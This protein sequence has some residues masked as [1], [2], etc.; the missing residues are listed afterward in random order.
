MA[1]NC[2][3]T[4]SIARTLFMFYRINFEKLHLHLHLLI[5]WIRSVVQPVRT[6]QSRGVSQSV[7][8]TRRDKPGM[9][10]KFLA[11]LRGI[12]LSTPVVPR[13]QI[14]VPLKW[15]CC[16][17][18]CEHPSTS[19]QKPTQLRPKHLLSRQLSLSDTCVSSIRMRSSPKVLDLDGCVSSQKP[20]PKDPAILKIL[21][22]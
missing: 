8:E 5:L 3:Y 13:G 2:G 7:R 20:Y 15:V 22:S 9:S 18:P 10:P 17:I 16:K 21:R 11:P 12:H 14:L 4:P 19:A 6:V 1:L